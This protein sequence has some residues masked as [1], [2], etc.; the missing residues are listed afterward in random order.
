MGHLKETF[1]PNREYWSL[2]I[3][4]LHNSH[5]FQFR[6]NPFNYFHKLSIKCL[7]NALDLANNKFY[8]PQEPFILVQTFSAWTP[9]GYM[10]R[11]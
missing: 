6:E 8:I 7:C 10:D 3:Y 11:L 2:F 1:S 4:L 9:I 5:S